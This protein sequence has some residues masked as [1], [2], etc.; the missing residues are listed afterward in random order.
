MK[1]IGS[2]ASSIAAAI[3]CWSTSSLSATRKC[4]VIRACSAALG[5]SLRAATGQAIASTQSRASRLRI[6]S[7]S[8]T[9]LAFEQLQQLLHELGLTRH[10]LGRERVDAEQL[11]VQRRE[12]RIAQDQAVDRKSTRL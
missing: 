12:R 9:L 6:S 8:A 4:P 10:A 11:A 7:Y 1:L 5:S 3:R 2:I